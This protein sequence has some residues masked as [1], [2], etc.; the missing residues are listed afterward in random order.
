MGP[1]RA[2]HRLQGPR[3]A[4]LKA[5]IAPEGRGEKIGVFQKNYRGVGMEGGWGG[6]SGP[7]EGL[8]R[9]RVTPGRTGRDDFFQLAKLFGGLQLA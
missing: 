7:L 3:E 8:T 1:S 6:H 9:F 4:V 2:C 5:Y